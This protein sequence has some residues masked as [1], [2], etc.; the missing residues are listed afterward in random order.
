MFLPTAPLHAPHTP[1]SAM[2]AAFRRPHRCRPRRSFVES[3]AARELC[4]LACRC[5]DDSRTPP[6]PAAG[7]FYACDVAAVLRRAVRVAMRQ[8]SR[9][10]RAGSR[11]FVYCGRQKHIKYNCP[12]IYR[13]TV[14]IKVPAGKL[15]MAG[16]CCTWTRGPTPRPRSVSVAVDG[17]DR[18]SVVADRMVGHPPRKMSCTRALHRPP[19]FALVDGRPQ[20]PPSGDR[21]PCRLQKAIKIEWN[22]GGAPA[23]P[24]SGVAG[25]AGSRRGESKCAHTPAPKPRGAPCTSDG[26]RRGGERA[27]SRERPP[28]NARRPCR[29]TRGP[30][31]RPR[32][33]DCRFQI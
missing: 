19:P 30:L 29:C 23:R 11:R 5:E 14:R 33:E 28:A 9:A 25:P 13:T 12:S 31:P 4:S 21:L 8:M 24:R 22:M 1:S 6:P 2:C 32:A 10:I 15:P 27:P 20:P 18:T 3:A 17:V 7:H 16:C 26:D